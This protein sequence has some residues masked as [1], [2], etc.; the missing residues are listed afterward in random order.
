MTNFL[1]V[2]K[3]DLLMNF[4]LSGGD[5]KQI[6]KKVGIIVLLLVAFALPLAAVLI[7]LYFLSQVA[8]FGGY[9][10]EL[11]NMIFLAVQLIVLVF[12]LPSYINSV[13]FSKDRQLLASMPIGGTAVFVSRMLVI[14]ISTLMISVP[15]TLIGGAVVA[16]G[17]ASAGEMYAPLIQQGELTLTSQ[18]QVYGTAGYYIMLLLASLTL[19]AAPLFVMAILSFPLMKIISYFKRNSALK[20][21]VMLVA[22]GAFFALIYVGSF[23]LQNSM[24]D[25]ALD[26]SMNAFDQL[27]VLIEKMCGFTRWLYP[28]YFAASAMCGAWQDG[29]YYALTII[30]CAA[31]VVLGSKFFFSLADTR[32]IINTGKGNSQDAEVKMKS[33]GVR[34]ALL[35][36]DLLCIMREPQLAFQSFAGAVLGPIVLAVINIMLPMG[37]QEGTEQFY[38]AI[39]AATSVLMII[40][41]TCGAN[42]LASVAVSR[43]GQSFKITRFMPISSRDIVI[44]KLALA[45]V[46]SFICIL[47]DDV[48]LIALSVFNV[49]D[50]FGALI[51]VTLVSM[52][53]N[54]YSLGRD[55]KNPKFVYNSV[56]ELV[57]SSS[58]TLTSMV[59]SL[60][61]SV[62]AMAIYIGISLSGLK[63]YAASGAI[64]GAITGISVIVCVIFRYKCV[65]RMSKGIDVIE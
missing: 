10:D 49:V 11:I 45:D 22:Y 57:K 12:F 3:L 2:F 30:A 19:P 50:F 8:V 48:I 1:S 38:P 41:L 28:S 64:W 9:L 53:V 13:W 52:G 27:N 32:A 46:F 33:T 62:A 20:T 43:E 6:A 55:I 65:T 16:A 60:I 25:I 18:A 42:I 36:K 4:K 24:Q 7:M 61:V 35:K 44:S 63:G 47:I 29:I 40:V 31:A 21:I 23:A 37:A 56:R 15:V 59:V 51:S 58:K 39:N 34:F 14:Y 5:K 54:A 26:G 17:S